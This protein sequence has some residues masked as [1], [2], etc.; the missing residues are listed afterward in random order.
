MLKYFRLLLLAALL[1]FSSPI[2]A[3]THGISLGYGDSKELNES[4][5]TYGLFV[6]GKVYRFKNIDPLLILTIDP[7]LGYWRTNT[8]KNNRLLTIAISAAFR[9]YFFPANH[10]MVTP[11][12]LATFGP[13][14]LSNKHLGT[15][16][17]GAHFAFQTT[18]GGGAELFPHNNHAVDVNLRMIHYCN[19]GLAK[20]N[21]G[22]DIFYV[23][24]V[25]YLF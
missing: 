8:P 9:A 18:L 25:G 11:Y 22:F 21:E 17:Q 15:Q 10:R 13:T 2:F 19:A 6:N 1:C 3:W 5:S 23:F 12:L 24:S 4:Y 14:Y 20:P 16:E 7:S